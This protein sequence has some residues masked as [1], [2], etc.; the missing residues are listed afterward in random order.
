MMISGIGQFH[1]TLSKKDHHQSQASCP[2][3]RL[4]V[5]HTHEVESGT[6][7]SIIEDPRTFKPMDLIIEEQ[8]NV[9][10]L[11]DLVG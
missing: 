8:Q 10:Q 6:R 7:Q 4:F 2:S 5:I 9:E 1:D 11:I 3:Y